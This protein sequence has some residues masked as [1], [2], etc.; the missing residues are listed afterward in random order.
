MSKIF[1]VVDV[2]QNDPC[3]GC[4]SCMRLKLM[5]MGFISGQLI[6]VED[7]KHGLYVVNILSEYGT[8]SSTLALRQEEFDRICLK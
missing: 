8:V 2:P 4:V 3:L 5:E 7:R 6:E 1:E